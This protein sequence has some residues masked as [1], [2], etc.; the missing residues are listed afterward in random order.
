MQQPP[1]S[2]PPPACPP[3]EPKHASTV[4]NELAPQ[5][6]RLYGESLFGAWQDPLDALEA[7]RRGRRRGR[8]DKRL[9]VLL[10]VGAVVATGTWL[11]RRGLT[12]RA[13]QERAQV[14]KDVATF[15]ADGELDRLAQYLG[16]LLPAAEPLQG[17]NPN[18]DLIVAAEAAL[19]RYQDA[20]PERLARIEPY[21][22]SDLPQP[23][24]TLARLTVA[25][26]PERA[27]A[28][29]TLVGLQPS[30][31]KN[32]EYHTL[33]ATVL[34]QRGDTKAARSAWGRSAQAGPLWLPH[35]Y[36]QC[37][38]E[39]RQHNAG[40]IADILAH[41]AKVAPE[42]AWTR[43]AYRHFARTMPATPASNSVPQQ[44]SAVGQYYD[45]MVQVFL[46]LAAHDLAA[47]RP[48]LGRALAA[49][50]GQTPFVLDA[51]TALVD[52]MEDGLA[53]EMTSYEE[54]PHSSRWARTK[55]TELQASITKRKLAAASAPGEPTT[56][57][58]PSVAMA[59]TGAKTKANTKA[60]KT[61]ASKKKV[62]RTK[63]RG[64]RRR[65]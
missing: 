64:G 9:A 39:A 60:K 6:G 13:E 59:N 37:A 26:R 52:A 65:K 32:P 30:L 55:S 42:S 38:F 62:V 34:D 19:Y 36:Q 7:N 27:E 43:M 25:S 57:S 50:H 4:D 49:I 47:A 63:K 35:R 21:L 11:Y 20:A 45:E 10:L 46:S 14:A 5:L 12:R 53:M 58:K 1:G 54:W 33:M 23:I 3:S 15:L 22:S 56:T 48:S 29:D 41:M 31:A 51:F 28:F 2:S 8:W 16:L 61:T 40:A 17:G 18:L 44:P 24:R